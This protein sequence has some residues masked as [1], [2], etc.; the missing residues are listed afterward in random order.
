MPL[1]KRDLSLFMTGA[2][3]VDRRVNLGY[4]RPSR[5]T[6]LIG[7]D[8]S[9]CRRRSSPAQVMCELVTEAGD[10]THPWVSRGAEASSR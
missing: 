9:E 5:K 3:F 1:N 4:G 7:G 8:K 6:S 2:R 10:E